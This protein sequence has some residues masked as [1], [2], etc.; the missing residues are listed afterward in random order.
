MEERE[1]SFNDRMA[2]KFS[3]NR[4]VLRIML[5]TI[6][7]IFKVVSLPGIRARH[8]W[9]SPQFNTSAVLPI[10]EELK[11]HGVPLP[12]P[13]LEEIVHKASHRMLMN[14]CGCRVAYQC[15]NHPR[16]LG[17]IF[18][19]PGVTHISPGL[20]RMVS[21]EEAMEHAKKAIASGLIPSV[22]KAEIDKVFYAMPKDAKFIGLCFC[23]HC[24]CLANAFTALPV[25]HLD[26]LFPRLKGLSIE[27]TDECN[28][29]GTCVEYCLYDAIRIEDGRAVH[30]EMCRGC[31]RCASECPS[32][33]ITISLDNDDFREE[34]ISRIS[35]VTGVI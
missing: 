1:L 33:A 18:M 7:A 29:C 6:R 17:C 14:V 28:G 34:I 32:D 31:G 8:R 21:P 15:K 25:E 9:V 24:C 3:K 35:R 2:A 4:V 20:G 13:I 27:I 12:L 30:T 11:S 19:G 23:C 22:G 5:D 26:R 10:N 16:D